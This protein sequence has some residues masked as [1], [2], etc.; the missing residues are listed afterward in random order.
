M[1]CRYCTHPVSE[2]RVKTSVAGPIS[3]DIVC[4]REVSRRFRFFVKR[5]GCFEPALKVGNDEGAWAPLRALISGEG[6][7]LPGG[8]D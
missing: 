6:W 8:A 2:H 4:D 5:C 1:T 3:F 7:L